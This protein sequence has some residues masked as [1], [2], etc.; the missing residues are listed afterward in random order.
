ME[1]NAKIGSVTFQRMNNN[2]IE[3]WVDG[4]EM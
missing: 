4:Y 1:Y 3:V 2:A